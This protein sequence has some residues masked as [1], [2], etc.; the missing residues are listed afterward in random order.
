MQ[1]LLLKKSQLSKRG[2]IFLISAQTIFVDIFGFLRVP[3]LYSFWEKV[4]CTPVNISFTIK[5][6]F[7][8]ILITLMC[9]RD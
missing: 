1:F 9:Y 6:G 5:L 4:W 2:D 8:G 7:E 3:T